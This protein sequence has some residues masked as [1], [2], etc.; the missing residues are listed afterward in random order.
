[1]H[2]FIYRPLQYPF[3]TGQKTLRP[4]NIWLLCAMWKYI[5]RINSWVKRP[6]SSDG[7][8]S[9]PAQLGFEHPGQH[10]NLILFFR[11]DSIMFEEVKAVGLLSWKESLRLKDIECNMWS[12]PRQLPDLYT[13]HTQLSQQTTVACFSGTLMMTNRTHKGKRVNCRLSAGLPTFK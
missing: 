9:P 13:A 2:F 11:H 10:A 4:A 5:F 3:H 6:C 8:S 12:E 1:M 7:Y